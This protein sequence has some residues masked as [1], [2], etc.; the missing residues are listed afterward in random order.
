M[1]NLF[2]ATNSITKANLTELK[3]LN[4]PP[5]EVKNT[6]LIF[7]NFYRINDNS[8]HDWA[9]VKICLKKPDA[10]A[11]FLKHFDYDNASG[12]SVK[13]IKSA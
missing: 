2:T 13:M 7:A 10:I 4:Y 9:S 11:A 6:L 1:S 3:A 5:Q 12:P 8:N